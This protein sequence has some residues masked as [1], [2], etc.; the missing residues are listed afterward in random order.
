MITAEQVK[1]FEEIVVDVTDGLKAGEISL[2]QAY[3]LLSQVQFEAV[4]ER[5]FAFVEDSEEGEAEKFDFRYLYHLEKCLSPLFAYLLKKM[6][7]E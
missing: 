3:L 5:L 7:K 4:F 2:D 6:G 1:K